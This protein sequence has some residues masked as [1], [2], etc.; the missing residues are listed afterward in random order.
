[1]ANY[2]N[3]DIYDLELTAL[4]RNSNLRELSVAIT[5]K[6]ILVF[7][8]IFC[9]INLQGNLLNRANYVGSTNFH[10]TE[11]TVN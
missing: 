9:T 3:F 1:M 8:D 10:E 7:E 11:S 2:L 6:S 5:N 4:T